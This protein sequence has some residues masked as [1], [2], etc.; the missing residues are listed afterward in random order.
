M[1]ICTYI[2]INK[3]IHTDILVCVVVFSRWAPQAPNIFNVCSGTRMLSRVG[4]GGMGSFTGGEPRAA[5][6]TGSPE[7]GVF[8]I[9]RAAAK[10][11]FGHDTL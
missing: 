3:Y 11:T 9:L 10:N 7:K 4:F 1:Y 8:E 2:H 5:T 6:N